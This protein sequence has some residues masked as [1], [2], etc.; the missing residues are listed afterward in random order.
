M[1]LLLA[2][3]LAAAACPA[4]PKTETGEINGAAFRI[5]VPENWNGGLVMYCHGY[6]PAAVKFAATEPNGVMRV[7]LDRGYAVAQSGYA[8]GGWAIEEA[9]EDTQELLRYFTR[10]YGAPKETYVTGHSM[11]G[12]LT[13]MLIERFPTS[14][15]AGLALCGPLAPA[16]GMIRQSAFDLRVIFD[17]YFPGVLPPPDNVPA[18]FAMSAALNE[19][20]AG[21]LESKPT[22]A[23]ALRRFAGIRTNS[24]LASALVFFTYV[25]KDIEQRSGGNPFDNRSVI[26]AGT[27]DDDAV[28]DGVKRYAADQR[29]AEY[30]LTWYTPTG[31]LLRPLLAIHTTY[32]P[33]VAPEVPN[34]YVT[35]SELGG[36]AGLF[37]Q[38]YV[39][40]G[41]HC[42]ILPAEIGRGFDELRKWKTDGTRPAAGAVP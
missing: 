29:A 34:H 16:A 41:G 6:N 40:H 42:A 38:Q 33:V 5:D 3:L 31:H 18:G 1:R 9:T 39:K 37:A 4:Q 36:S 2:F 32:D 23:E 17:Y 20:V 27:G 30:L 28:N 19:K 35:L 10:K 8:A 13:M 21:L 26:Y 25:L 22:Q 11:G 14:Y 24:E 15:D 12:F 7:F